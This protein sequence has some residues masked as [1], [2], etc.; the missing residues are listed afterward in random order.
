MISGPFSPKAQPITVVCSDLSGNCLGRALVLAELAQTFGP[1]KIVG[2]QSG[3]ARWAPSASSA[4]PML[5]RKI[6]ASWGYLGAA[7]WLKRQLLGSK[8]VV[9]KPL[10]SSLGLARLA[11]VSP[12]HMLLDIDD[13]EVGL[14]SRRAARGLGF[15]IGQLL[16][17]MELNAYHSTLLLDRLLR[18]FPHITTSNAWLQ[19]KYGGQVLPHV[20]DTD[21]LNPNT[22]DREAIRAKLE[23]EGRLWVGFIGTVRPHK[24]VGQLIEVLGEFHGPDAPGLYVA[25]VDLTD[26]YYSELKSEAEAKLGT[27]R[28]RFR[29]PFD[30]SQLPEQVAPVD[31]ICLPGLNDPGATGQLPAKLMDAMAMGKPVVASGHND[32]SRLLDGCGEIVTPG[33]VQELALALRRVLGDAELRANYG[34]L[35]RRRAESELSYSYGRRIMSALLVQ[36]PTFEGGA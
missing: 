26:G 2:L 32:V 15:R 11:G 33:V 28:V 14:R 7:R 23:M 22:V 1:T 31:V 13:W 5:E 25:G 20:R 6:G 30:F 3:K 9:S 36:L 4:I 27:D 34:E 16:N 12:D 21:W 29:A 35:A 17:P 19:E 24:G 8:V 18:D 10:F